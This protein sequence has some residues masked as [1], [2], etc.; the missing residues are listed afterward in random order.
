M[1]KLSVNSRLLVIGLVISLLVSACSLATK[2]ES[3]SN[4]NVSSKESSTSSSNT[5]SSAP[6]PTTNNKGLDSKNDSTKDEKSRRL[7]RIRFLKLRVRRFRRFRLTLTR[8]LTPMCVV[9]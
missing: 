6:A 3:P 4:S 7:T 5:M 1:K 8:L 9:I 2:Q